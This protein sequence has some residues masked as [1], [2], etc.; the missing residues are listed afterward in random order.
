MLLR[1][2]IR[3][4]NGY[5]VGTCL[6]LGLSAR[7]K[8]VRE[9]KRE[10]LKLIDVHL[11]TVIELREAGESVIKTPVNY[12]FFKKLLFDCVYFCTARR[13]SGRVEPPK[14]SFIT[15]VVV[16]AGI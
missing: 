5:F 7:G 4:Q 14:N 8:S 1:C 11:N 10:L 15:E 16:P 13:N 12:Y 6:E 3:R 2:M 9:C